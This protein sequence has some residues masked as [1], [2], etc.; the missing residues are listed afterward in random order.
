MKRYNRNR[1]SPEVNQKKIQ[2]E[3]GFHFFI[4]P[5]FLILSV[6]SC[7]EKEEYPS[8]EILL[9]YQENADRFCR[10]VVECFKKDAE[11][12][13]E[14]F[15]ER[16]RLITSKMDMDLCRQNQY[17]LIGETSVSIHKTHPSSDPEHYR[18]YENCSLAVSSE[19]DC[20][21]RLKIYRTNSDCKRIKQKL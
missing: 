10:S 20:E 2:K 16:S 13:L 8:E 21:S 17:K 3:K 19:K 14:E 4:I 6:F 9:K 5:F 15:P 1:F 11:K 12:R 7:K 18:I